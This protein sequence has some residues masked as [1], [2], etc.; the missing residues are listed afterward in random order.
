MFTNCLQLFSKYT[1]LWLAFGCAAGSQLLCAKTH[2]NRILSDTL[3][4]CPWDDQ[5]G[6]LSES[7][8]A[9]LTRY[10]DRYNGTILD[11]DL[12]IANPAQSFSCAHVDHVLIRK[13]R[14]TEKFHDDTPLP[15]GSL[16]AEKEQRYQNHLCRLSPF[17]LRMRYMT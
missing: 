16:Y 9:A 6:R 15:S 10:N 13:L 12:N 4:P 8:Q 1:M 7:P 14:I 11:I 3:D 2:K 17:A 5:L